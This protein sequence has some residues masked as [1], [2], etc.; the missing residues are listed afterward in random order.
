M[1]FF[2]GRVRLQSALCS[3]REEGLPPTGSVG[4]ALWIRGGSRPKRPIKPAIPRPLRPLTALQ[5]FPLAPQHSS[6]GPVFSACTHEP[7]L[8]FGT[9]PPARQGGWHVLDP[10]T[11]R[12]LGHGDTTRYDRKTW[13]SITFEDCEVIRTRICDAS[14]RVNARFATGINPTSVY[15]KWL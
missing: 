2:S 1:G 7:M 4:R 3:P 12:Y 14:M 6:V 13:T 5:S 11:V 9:P 10:C 8:L 15:A